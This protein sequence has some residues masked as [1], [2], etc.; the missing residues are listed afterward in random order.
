M[1]IVIEARVTRPVAMIGIVTGGAARVC[2]IGVSVHEHSEQFVE[3]F[4]F[5]NTF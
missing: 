2:E 1:S 5:S 3:E 4:L